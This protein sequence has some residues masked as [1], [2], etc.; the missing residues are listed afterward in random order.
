MKRRNVLSR[1]R[2]PP[3]SS[4]SQRRCRHYLAESNFENSVSLL[5]D[6]KVLRVDRG[7]RVRFVFVRRQIL[8]FGWVYI[9]RR[10]FFLAYEPGKV[11]TRVS[12]RIPWLARTRNSTT[13]GRTQ[14]TYLQRASFRRLA[15]INVRVQKATLPL[16]DA[17]RVI[18]RREE[19]NYYVS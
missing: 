11:D 6:F 12:T 15:R 7:Q 14:A 2:L 4:T 3:S 13:S 5:R 16:R 17:P 18:K 8:P 1:I 19:R 9:P 10:F